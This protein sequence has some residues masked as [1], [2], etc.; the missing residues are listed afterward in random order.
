MRISYSLIN[1]NRTT[2]RNGNI[3]K[4]SYY[5][6]SMIK[7]LISQDSFIS[8]N[9]ISKLLFEC[10]GMMFDYNEN[11]FKNNETIYAKLN[12]IYNSIS[13]TISNLSNENSSLRRDYNNLYST[14]SNNERRISELN[15]Q[16][17]QNQSRISDLNYQNQQNQSRINDLS[18]QNEKL[19]QKLQKE[20]NLRKEEKEKF[21]KFKKIFEEE[22]IKIEKKHIG[23]SK[24]YIFKFI[25]NKFLKE[26]ETKIEKKNAFTHSL[27]QYMEKFNEEYMQYCRNF[28]SSFK[29]NSHKIVN[30]FN[31]NDNNILIEHINFIVIGKAG[32][33]KSS[34]I[35][36]SLRLPKEKRAK[37]G[38]GKS[39]TSQS[40]LYNSDTL[41]MIRMW[42]TQGLDYKVSQEYILNEVKGIVE[43]GLKK[44]PD[45]YINIILYCTTG[46]R[47]QDEDGQFIYEIM[48]LYPS[49]NLPVIITQLQAFFVDRVKEMEKTIRE[50]L[51][52]YLDNKIAKKIEIRDVVARDQ[53]AESV[54]FKAR[55]IPELLRLSVELMGRAI[56]QPL[57]KNFLKKL[58]IYVKILLIKK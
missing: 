1:E 33:E 5:C 40:K 32:V 3:R 34:F 24:E 53:K 21:E 37:E 6:E 55:G 46:E 13:Q 14:N 27:I 17:Q 57:V 36:E 51:S 52:N 23:I 8:K 31:I 56:I 11:H 20:E 42:D 9:A 22:K 12:G 54:V 44:G 41:K 19:N 2:I 30:E 47:F 35:N 4:P 48:K 29:A 39:I 43:D 26:F 10:Y 38:I 28:L 50:I 16:N 45:H 18:Q 25:I 7:T 49:D 15:Y 58:K